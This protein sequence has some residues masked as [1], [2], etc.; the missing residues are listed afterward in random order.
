MFRIPL[1]YVHANIQL[2]NNRVMHV[3]LHHIIVYNKAMKYAY[4]SII[5]LLIISGFYWFQLRPSQIKKHCFYTSATL[6]ENL[7][8]HAD[9][10]SPDSFSLASVEAQSNY[11]SCLTS[12]G[13]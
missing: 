3:S 1:Y 5:I 11:H 4:L 6:K 2:F 8:P 10:T 13:L 12:N 7:S 9:L